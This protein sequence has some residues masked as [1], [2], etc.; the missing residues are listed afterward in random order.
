MSDLDWLDGRESM[1]SSGVRA[2][3]GQVNFE[4]LEDDGNTEL[5]FPVRLLEKGFEEFLGLADNGS[6][7][8]GC[9]RMH[10]AGFA[11]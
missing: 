4:R 3:G 9:W 8:I 1:P 10:H 11:R 5:D 6:A 2:T 7:Y